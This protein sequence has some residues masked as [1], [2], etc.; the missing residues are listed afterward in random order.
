MLA[1]SFRY[2]MHVALSCAASLHT[3]MHAVAPAWCLALSQL[4]LYCCTTLCFVC[5]TARHPASPDVSCT[6]PPP[7]PVSWCWADC[8]TGCWLVWQRLVLRA[9]A[10]CTGG[11]LSSCVGAVAPC[12]AAAGTSVCALDGRQQQCMC[13][14]QC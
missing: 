5:P 1:R 8:A 10:A 9:S 4:M 3:P 6:I 12:W 13:A 11:A 2:R 14:Q 7:P